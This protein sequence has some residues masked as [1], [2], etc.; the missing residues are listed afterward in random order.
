MKLFVFDQYKTIPKQYLQDSIALRIFIRE[1]M[2]I[3]ISVLDTYY[4]WSSIS[5]DWCAKWLFIDTHP[6]GM[7]REEFLLSEMEKKGNIVYNVRRD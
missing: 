6:E 7:T 4:L 2:D 3:D 1:K 5:E